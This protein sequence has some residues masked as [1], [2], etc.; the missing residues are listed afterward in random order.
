MAQPAVDCAAPVVANQPLAQL[1]CSSDR[2]ARA[3]LS[4]VIAY[5]ALRQISNDAEQATMRA[6]AD[7]FTGRITDECGIPRTGRLG[8]R[9]AFEPEVH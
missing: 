4:Y 8:G 5:M 2:I 9:P 7:A 6:D 1:I 3:E